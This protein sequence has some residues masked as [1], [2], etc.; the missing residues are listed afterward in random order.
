MMM[1]RQNSRSAIVA[2]LSWGLAICQPKVWLSPLSSRAPP[3]QLLAGVVHRLD[4]L[5]VGAGVFGDLVDVAADLLHHLL[6][7]LLLRGGGDLGGG[8]RSPDRFPQH[9]V[10]VA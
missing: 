5:A 1:A 3:E 4:L 8:I 10:Q 7:L 2:L 6:L 9:Q